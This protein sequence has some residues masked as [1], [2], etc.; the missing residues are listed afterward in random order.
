[1]KY[2]NM[3]KL[4]AI[5]SAGCI[6]ISISGCKKHEDANKSN[7][8]DTGNYQYMENP[9][10]QFKLESAE[11]SNETQVGETIENEIITYFQGLEE[12]VNNCINAESFEKVKEK[13]KEMF[14]TGIDF[15]FYCKEIKGVTFEELTTEAQERIMYIVA[16]IDSKIE[17]KIP[18]YK[19]TI[20]DKFGQGYDYVSEKLQEGLK[21]IDGKLDEKYGEDYQG[22]KDKANEITD[23]VKDGASSIYDEVTESISEGF[24][25]IKD[26]YEDKTDK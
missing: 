2:I 16:N 12:E 20:K 21:Y 10:E 15:I 7:V 26:W 14:I 22:V 17:S 1:M 24:Q 6:L 8:S 25:K 13:A 11:S 4:I 19:E 5:I 23:E 18:G 3:K 9:S